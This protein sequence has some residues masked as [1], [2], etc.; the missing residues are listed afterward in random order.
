[1]HVC[2]RESSNERSSLAYHVISQLGRVP[3]YVVSRS[4]EIPRKKK[5]DPRS[6]FSLPVPP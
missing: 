3:D 4:S 1:M 5:F 6:F 2:R